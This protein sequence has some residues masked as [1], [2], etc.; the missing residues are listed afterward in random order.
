MKI[1][2]FVFL[3]F[4]HAQFALADEVLE[5]EDRAMVSRLVVVQDEID[6]VSSAVMGCMDSGRTHKECM[7]ENRELFI[8][9]TGTVNALFVQ[10]PDLRNHD[11]VMFKNQQGQHVTQSMEGIQKQ[12]NMNLSCNE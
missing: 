4:V 6:A 2:L 8:R 12:A 9:F 5:V 7:C 10:Y 3:F 11:L 1:I